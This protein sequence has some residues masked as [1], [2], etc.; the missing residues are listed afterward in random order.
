MLFR[1]SGKSGSDELEIISFIMK[2][3]EIVRT[4]LKL[5]KFLESNEIKYVNQDSLEG[6]SIFI[7]VNVGRNY[8]FSFEF[9]TKKL[10]ELLIPKEVGLSPTFQKLTKNLF[11]SIGGP[12]SRCVHIYDMNINR[13]Y[14]IGEL[15]SIRVGAYAVLIKEYKIVYICGGKNEDGDD[16][17]E[18]EYFKLI[19]E[20]DSGAALITSIGVTNNDGVSGNPLKDQNDCSLSE[21]FYPTELKKKKSFK[22][23]FLLRKS[24]P[25]VIPLLQIDS[26]LICGGDNIFGPTKTCVL[27]E[28]AKDFIYLTNSELPKFIHSLNPIT[29]PYKSSNY[30]FYSDGNAVISYSYIDGVFQIIE[31]NVID[32]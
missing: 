10:T 15:N 4:K 14:Y 19:F 28:A 8:F 17:L 16:T 5:F 2:S 25:V 12:S 29:V 9:I 22:N 21:S 3:E 27:Y 18:I 23:D 24:H 26:Y 20:E 30:Y 1:I 11:I 7:L 13:W 32:I 6:N 31:K